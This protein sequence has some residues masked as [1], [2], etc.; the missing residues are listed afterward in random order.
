MIKILCVCLGNLS[1]SQMAAAWLHHQLK[2][3]P[4]VYID[5]AGS[6]HSIGPIA[7]EAV[8]VLKENGLEPLR[9]NPFH[10]SYKKDIDWDYV[11]LFDNGAEKEA[12]KHLTA[13]HWLHLP[14]FDPADAEPD[15]LLQAHRDV[16][17]EIKF[18]LE[19]VVKLVRES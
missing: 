15:Q 2:D 3:N 14:V 10:V 13:K 7:P 4:N 5:S 11:I 19:E 1:R 6:L 12:K 18:K 9:N 16:F 17:D 8:T